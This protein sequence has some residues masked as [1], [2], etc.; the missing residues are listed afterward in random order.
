MGVGSSDLGNRWRYVAETA[1]VLWYLVVPGW[2]IHDHGNVRPAPEPLAVRGQELAERIG[3]E[4]LDVYVWEHPFV[5]AIPLGDGDHGT[6]VLSTRLLE[7][8]DGEPLDAAMAHEIGH[9]RHAHARQFAGEL[10]VVAGCGIAAWR[11]YG[12]NRR[13][14]VRWL[15]IPIAI[16]STIAGLCA[17]VRR[18]ER[19][20]D[21]AAQ[22]ALEDPASL[23]RA[24]LAVGTGDPD[25]DPHTYEPA[26]R[27]RWT[28]LFSIYPPPAD[29]FPGVVGTDGQ[30]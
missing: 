8:L 2:S 29:R 11:L 23:A 7:L 27:S 20:A 21:A 5:N 18:Y 26:S 28:R 9:I 16:V 14:I 4:S 13:P 1:V 3:V 15:A 10:V 22:P 25:V 6:L 24:I 17:L 12:S 19:Q 30:V